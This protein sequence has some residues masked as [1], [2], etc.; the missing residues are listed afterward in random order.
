MAVVAIITKQPE[1]RLDDVLQRLYKGR[2]TRWSPT[3]A[4][5]ST[6]DT[7]AAMAPKIGVKTRNADGTL[8][9]EFGDIFITQLSPSYWGFGSTAFWD[10]LKTAFE[11]TT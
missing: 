5:V 10:W 11:T 3:T 9:G 8:T 7:P 2:F 4:V 1:P 6:T